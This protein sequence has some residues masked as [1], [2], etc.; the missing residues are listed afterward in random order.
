MPGVAMELFPLALH[1]SMSEF[2]R[3]LSIAKAGAIPLPRRHWIDQKASPSFNQQKM[4]RVFSPFPRG[5][6]RFSTLSPCYNLPRGL[7]LK[8]SVLRYLP[9]NN[10]EYLY[11]NALKPIK[12][13]H[14]MNLCNTHFCSNWQG[15][16]SNMRCLFLVARYVCTK[17]TW[18]I[19][20]SFAGAEKSIAGHMTSTQH[21]FYQKMCVFET[22]NI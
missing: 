2:P 8:N 15:P 1:F 11:E 5:S 4:G 21:L 22:T 14:R 16:V 12:N 6:W 10:K 9:E 13:L 17:E 3:W 20:I 7:S 19:F 18:L